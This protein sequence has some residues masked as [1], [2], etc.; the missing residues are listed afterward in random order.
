[1]AVFTGVCVLG[2]SSFPENTVLHCYGDDATCTGTFTTET[3]DE[4]FYNLCC[5]TTSS[6]FDAFS[7]SAVNP[8]YYSV[9]GGACQ[10]CMGKN[11]VVI[12]GA[13]CM[14]VFMHDYVSLPYSHYTA[15]SYVATGCL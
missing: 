4:L 14:Y 15:Y 1:M 2:Q 12:I 13:P 8:G 5:F 3:E 6:P 11:S 10:S 9:A 7:V